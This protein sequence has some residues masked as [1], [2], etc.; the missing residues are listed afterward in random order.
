MLSMKEL[1]I[2]H[3]RISQYGELPIVELESIF[4]EFNIITLSPDEFFYRPKED[5][6]VVAFQIDGLIRSYILTDKGEERTIDFCKSGDIL[7]TVDGEEQSSSWIQAIKQTTLAVINNRKLDIIVSNN[8][9]LQIVLMKML[10]SCLSLKSKR[11]IE[12]LSL[13]GKERYLKFLTDFKDIAE[14]IPQF[15]IASYLGISPVSLSRIKK[16]L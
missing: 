13:D 9:K 10:E 1:D 12:L 6:E 7:S 11:E 4:K 3:S 5:K 2:I 8:S 15:Q 16:S 14:D